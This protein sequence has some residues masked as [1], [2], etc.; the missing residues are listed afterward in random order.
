MKRFVPVYVRVLSL[1]TAAGITTSILFLHAADL[2]T[3]G[4]PAAAAAGAAVVA[5]S[6]GAEHAIWHG[7]TRAS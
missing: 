6:D 7:G 2:S 5:K 4:A 1:L 3:L